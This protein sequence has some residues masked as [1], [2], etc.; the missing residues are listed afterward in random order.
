MYTMT[1]VL[2]SSNTVRLRF[3]FLKGSAVP[4]YLGLVIASFLV[5][6][7]YLNLFFS[8]QR[9]HY[10]NR[11]FKSFLYIV[12]MKWLLLDSLSSPYKLMEISVCQNK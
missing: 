12:Y 8:T 6:Y 10:M 9:I 3:F 11:L 2:Y 7:L 5:N 4:V 1:N